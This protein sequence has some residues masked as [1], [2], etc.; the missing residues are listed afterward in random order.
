MR[1]SARL[2]EALFQSVSGAP[3]S[4]DAGADRTTADAVEP[5]KLAQTLSADSTKIGCEEHHILANQRSTTSPTPTN[6]TFD[7]PAVSRHITVDPSQDGPVRRVTTIT[8]EWPTWR[9]ISDHF[10][11]ETESRRRASPRP[12]SNYDLKRKPDSAANASTH[13]T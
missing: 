1:S 7:G 12:L 4:L 10:T 11:R 8:Q 6:T 3:R 5:T 9:R 2:D 13:F